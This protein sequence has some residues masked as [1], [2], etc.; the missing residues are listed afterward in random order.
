MHL[1]DAVAIFGREFFVVVIVAKAAAEDALGIAFTVFYVGIGLQYVLDVVTF[2]GCA[3]TIVN[4]GS[5]YHVSGLFTHMA[6]EVAHTKN[7]AAKVVATVD[8]VAQVR[9]TVQAYVAL[10]VAQDVGIT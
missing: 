2:C 4:V 6:G 5:V 9:E 10:S 1:G 8:V 7:F 3:C